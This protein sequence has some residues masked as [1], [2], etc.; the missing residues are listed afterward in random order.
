MHQS[1]LAR[2]STWHNLG[3]FADFEKYLFWMI[4]M[5]MNKI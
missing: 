3:I 4:R 2:A 5:V 1:T